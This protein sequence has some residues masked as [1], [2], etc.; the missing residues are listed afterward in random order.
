ML[1]GEEVVLCV[2]VFNPLPT[3]PLSEEV[4][5]DSAAVEGTAGVAMV[6]WFDYDCDL[7]TLHCQ[8][9]V[10]TSWCLEKSWCLLIAPE[11]SV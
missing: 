2:S 3:E 8:M 11:G 1:E 6:L 7:F 4:V 5:V 10:I 9:V